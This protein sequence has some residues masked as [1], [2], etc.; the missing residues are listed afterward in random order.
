MS[1]AEESDLVVRLMEGYGLER[2]QAERV[3]EE[4]RHA[5]GSTLEEWVRSRHIRLQRRGLRNED[6][7][8]LL[9]E[10]IPL[11]RF[12]AAPLSIR[13]IRRLIYG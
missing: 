9:A 10:E 6:I 5:Y 12:A 8:R 7:Y 4:V 2:L 3:I 11:Y 1:N 13:Q